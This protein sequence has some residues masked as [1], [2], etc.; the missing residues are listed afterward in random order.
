MVSGAT[1]YRVYRRGAGQSTWTY[2]GT[3]T[4]NTFTDKNVVKNNYYRYTVRAVSGYYSGF[5]TNGLYIKR[6]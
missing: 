3:V 4:T 6:T 2:L 5:D 1:G